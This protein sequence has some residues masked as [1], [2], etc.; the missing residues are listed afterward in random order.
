MPPPRAP[1][2]VVG[3]GQAAAALVRGLRELG[4]RGEIRV[5][6]EEAHAPYERP[7]LSKQVLLDPGAPLGPPLLDAEGA[8]AEG[9]HLQL[10]TRV[11]SIDRRRKHVVTDKG[12]TIPYGQ[13]VLATGGQPRPLSGLDPDNRTLFA[14]RTLDDARALGQAMG[15][16]RRVLVVGGGWLGLEVAAAARQRGKEV[17]LLETAERLCARSVPPVVSAF[18]K[19]LHRAHGVDVRLGGSTRVER[20][21]DALELVGANGREAFDLAV[22]AV[23]LRANDQLASAAGLETC[24]GVLTDFSGRTSDPD[25]FAIG[26]VSRV[27]V[28]GRPEGLRLESWRHAERQARLAAETIMDTPGAYREAAWFWSEQYDRLIQIAGLPAS[29]LEVLEIMPGD[30]PLWRLGRAGVVKAVIG[31]NRSRELRGHHRA[32]PGLEDADP[33]PGFTPE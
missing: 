26:D 9:T 22:V 12:E 6:G 15:R 28:S 20:R 33:K 7:P 10:S 18:L 31:V 16:A 13:L 4:F 25:I 19:E 23:G 3:A 27:R 2:V 30:N 17:T 5:I 24:D 8:R 29:D 14:L 11:A 21:G 32:L 1:I